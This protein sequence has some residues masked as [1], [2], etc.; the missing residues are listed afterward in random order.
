MK[1]MAYS[2]MSQRLMDEALV[3]S[4]NIPLY[5]PS[6]E[7]IIGLV[8]RNGN[9][10]IERIELSNSSQTRLKGPI[11]IGERMMHLRAAW[12]GMLSR[13]FGSEIIDLVYERIREKATH[14]SKKIESNMRYRSQLF[15]ALK[16]K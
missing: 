16:R 15:V 9:F 13:H 8:E 1:N 14:N 10:T 5:F 12:E 7:E 3:D 11:D 2:F 6:P 4:F